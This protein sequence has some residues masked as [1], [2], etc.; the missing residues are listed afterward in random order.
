MYGGA[1]RYLK[2][3]EKINAGLALAYLV[4]LW[5]I[6]Y[7]VFVKEFALFFSPVSVIIL[8]VIFGPLAFYTYRRHKWHKRESQ[9]FRRG[10][11]GEDAIWYELE[12]LSDDFVI[13]QDMR[14]GDKGNID[15]VVLGP[16]GLFTIEV[17]SNY[18]LVGF[19]GEELTLNGRTFQ[20]KNVLRQAMAEALALHDYLKEKLGEDIF[21]QPAIAFASFWTRM[22]FGFRAIQNVY[23]VRKRLLRLLVEQRQRVYSTGKI[24]KIE[25]VLCDVVSK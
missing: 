25:M 8:A 16:T 1:S 23:V 14:L 10:R 13:F 11:K 2:A 6:F 5:F 3:F 18:G 24:V 21:V 20:G 19:N 9:N 15:F 4:V 7:V 12:K 22:Y 17:K